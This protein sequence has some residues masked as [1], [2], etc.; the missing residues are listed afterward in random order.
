MSQQPPQGASAAPLA[1]ELRRAV[2]AEL[3]RRDLLE[4]A[5]WAWPR[6]TGKP[7]VRNRA[8]DEACSVLSRVATG[9][10]RRVA[11]AMPSGVG[12]STLL[13]V[14]SAWRLARNP[15]HRA[16]HMM[17]ASALAN[18]ESIRVRRLVE[19]DDFRALFPAVRLREDESTIASWATS[20]GG[21]YFAVGKDSSL[22]GRRA[23]EA[24]LDDPLDLVDRYSRAAK[25]SL[26]SWFCDA[27]MTRLDGDDAPCVVVHQRTAVDD[28]IGRLIEQG[29]WHVLELP[30]EDENGNLLAPTVL[31]REKLDELKARNPRGYSAMFLQ[32]PSADDGAAIPRTAWRFH[33]PSGS[34]MLAARPMGCATPEDA[35]TVVTP[36]RWD[37]TCISVDPT[38]GGTK[39]SN[40]FASIQVWSSAGAARYMRARWCKRAKQLEQRAQ[41]KAFRREYPSAAILIE[42]SAGGMG[43]AEELEA[44]GIRNVELITVGSMTGGKA[45]RLDNVSPTILL[46][47]AYI[48]LGLADLATFVECLFGAT[49]HDDDLDAC[50]QAL[51]WLNMR[52]G[53]VQSVSLPG[54][55]IT[56]HTMP[57]T[58]DA[59]RSLG[60]MAILGGR[61][62]SG[63]AEQL[64]RRWR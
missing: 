38:F 48:G 46:G 43:M 58:G 26:W 19:S 22:L 39:T 62:G 14:Y 15:A 55:A 60:A 41:V 16:I 20:A 11:I 56:E 25:E 5:R 54:H 47:Q 23:M 27:L 10:L 63:R 24:V 37:Q 29:G 6:I 3:L 18:T 53:R 45:A 31:G 51:H 34:N 4:M 21:R 32:R 42:R 50:S 61:G 36:S 64:T 13:A 2:Q 44:E 59:R 12:K 57:M 9:D 30:A 49:G 8:I 52:A 35:P 7:L 33:A 28:L 40:D 1:G 17:H